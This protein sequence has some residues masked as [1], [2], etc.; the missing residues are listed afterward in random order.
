MRLNFEFPEQ[1]VMELRE[2][3]KEVGVD[4]KT[5][6][7]TALTVFEWCIEETRRGNEIAAVNEREKTYRVLIAPPLQ[8]MARK[9]RKAPAL[10]EA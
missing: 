4:M 5:L 6:F 1:R 2:L 7:N 3:Q 8:A 10:S 9:Y